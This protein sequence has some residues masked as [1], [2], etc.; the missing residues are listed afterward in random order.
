MSY[1]EADLVKAVE[2]VFKCYD[3][4]HSGTLEVQ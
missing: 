1:S 2:A 4:D 3:A